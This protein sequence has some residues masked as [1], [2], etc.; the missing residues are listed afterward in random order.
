M[1]LK[2]YLALV[3]GHTA[4]LRRL[5]TELSDTFRHLEEDL[6]EAGSPLDTEALNLLDG[7]AEL[8]NGLLVAEDLFGRRLHRLLES[9]NLGTGSALIN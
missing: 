5:A 1:D 2:R 3:Q 4:Q 7:I 8:T 9:T 6:D